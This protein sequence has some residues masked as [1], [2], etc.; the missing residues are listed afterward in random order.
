MN[1]QKAFTLIELLVVIAIIGL[2][3]STVL[4]S[5]SGARESAREAAIL[6][7][8]NSAR[9]QAAMYYNDNNTYS[10]LCDDEQIQRIVANASST[11]DGAACWEAVNA[12]GPGLTMG[13]PD[14]MA[15]SD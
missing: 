15:R 3:S 11:G 9:T 10:G 8:L 1:T 12:P 7:A 2:L 14:L 5:L 6:S 13:D 4:A